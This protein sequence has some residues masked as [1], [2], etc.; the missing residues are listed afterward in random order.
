MIAKK[1]SR[2]VIYENDWVNLYADRVQFPNGAIIEKYHVLHYNHESV[3]I[4]I[5]NEKQNILM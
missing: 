3:G 1:L 5:I 2:E 4:V